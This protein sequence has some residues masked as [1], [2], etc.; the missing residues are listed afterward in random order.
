M[1]TTN[2]PSR[3]S[4]HLKVVFAF[5]LLMAASSWA[6]LDF[7]VDDIPVQAYTG[8]SVC[9]NVVVK[10]GEKTLEV[11]TDYTV[12][13]FD[14]VEK[15]STAP[16]VKITGMGIYGGVIEK[17]F[18]ILER[19]A[20]YAAVGI[21]KDEDGHS[22]AAIDGN[23][24]DDGSVNI[25]EEITVDSVMFERSFTKNTR[26]TI[27]LPFS[28]STS[29]IKGLQ[30][31]L[32]FS[33]IVD[34]KTV[35][36]NAIW[37]PTASEHVTL[38]AYTPYIVL[39]DG[40]K[41]NISGSVTLEVSRDAVDAGSEENSEW[42][43]RGSLSYKKWEEDDPELGSVYGF[44]ASSD[45]DLGVEAGDFVRVAAGAWINPMRAYIVQ[46]PSPTGLPKYNADDLPDNMSIVI[47]KGDKN[48]EG[49]HTTVIGKTNTLAG[50]LRLNYEGKRTF[51]IKGRN[52]GTPK[53]K[54]MYLKK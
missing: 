25:D 48:V 43:F 9:P 12:E 51:D 31:V 8:N 7:V 28:V 53:A 45:N 34:K 29:Q 20:D 23:Y 33:K 19:T 11:M 22:I 10:D 46:K 21:F 42:E 44:A 27:I 40:E 35:E 14:N 1:P 5:A 47:V 4:F 32:A 16:Y 54:G 3:L 15:S 50:K 6:D 49:E 2:C 36:M 30:Q 24:G 13:C 39:M 26:S 37:D 52:V 41:L 17:H 18:V 38:N